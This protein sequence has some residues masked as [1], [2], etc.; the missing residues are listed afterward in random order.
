MLHHSSEKDFQAC[1]CNAR[2]VV[3]YHISKTGS[4]S[5]IPLQ[6]F[7]FKCTCSLAHS[8]TGLEDHWCGSL[9]SVELLSGEWFEAVEVTAADDGILLEPCK[10]GFLNWG[11]MIPASVGSVKK[12][13]WLILWWKHVYDY[14]SKAKRNGWAYFFKRT[15][16]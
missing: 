11:G 3:S 10:E 8:S 7:D 1:L 6:Y 2:N 14:T 5:K 9:F 12:P 16:I 4:T 13:S 15:K